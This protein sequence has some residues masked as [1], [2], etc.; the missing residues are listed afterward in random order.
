[1]GMFKKLKQMTGSVDKDLLRNGLLGRG[2]IMEVQQTRVS[3]GG[4]DA[5]SRPVCVFTVEVTL[6]NVPAY[7]AS[8]RQSVP[9][10]VL[11]QFVPGQTVAA[12]RV[13][14]DNHDEIALDLATEPPEVTIA[15]SQGASAAEVLE[16]G[17]PVRAVIVQTQPLGMKNQHG[18]D[19]HAFVLTV[20]PDGQKPYQ[21]K[22]GNPVPDEGVPLLFP[23][24]NLPAKVLPEEPEGVVID[25]KAAM[26]EF[27][28]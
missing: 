8:C 24:S 1:M 15:Q 5:F 16:R 19:V 6:D 28:K 17:N 9:L 27:T 20:M 18:V 7:T 4:D 22:V 3:T 14:P 13:N 10:T 23:G 12:V 26:A 21:T 11:P 2:V 25:F